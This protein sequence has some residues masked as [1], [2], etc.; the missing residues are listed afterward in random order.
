[1]AEEVKVTTAS[2]TDGIGSKSGDGVFDTIMNA[3]KAH[4]L[5]EYHANRITGAEYTQAYISGLQTAMSQAVQFTLSK[6]R[7]EYDINTLV[8]QAESMD[9]QISLVEAQIRQIDKQLLL[10]DEQIS[11]AKLEQEI[12][13][14]NRNWSPK[15]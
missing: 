12:L 1:M 6:D 7:V 5:G 8:K 13:A 11:M 15:R 3:T 9:A 14:E 2:L 4:L 10:L